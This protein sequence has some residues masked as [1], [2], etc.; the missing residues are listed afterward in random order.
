MKAIE[1]GRQDKKAFLILP[2]IQL[3]TKSSSVSNM[4][5]NASIYIEAYKRL[6]INMTLT[7]KVM[8]EDQGKIMVYGGGGVTTHNG[9]IT[10]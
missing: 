8:E 5:S 1:I 9:V 10:P 2:N 4:N 6:V 3:I 7:M